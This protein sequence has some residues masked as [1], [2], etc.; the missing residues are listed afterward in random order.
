[1]GLC[2]AQKNTNP[3]GSWCLWGGGGGGVGGGGGG[4]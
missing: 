2:T 3:P 1:M 4:A